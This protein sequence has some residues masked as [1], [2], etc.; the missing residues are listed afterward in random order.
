MKLKLVESLGN[1]FLKRGNLSVRRRIVFQPQ[2]H[3]LPSLPPV[4]QNVTAFRDDALQMRFPEWALMQDDGCTY[5]RKFRYRHERKTWGENG[6]PE[7]KEEGLELVPP[8]R[9][10]EGANPAH[11]LSSDFQPPDLCVKRIFGGLCPFICSS[12]L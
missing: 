2:V 7:A 5:K 9:P 4:T 12:S 6:L 8:S 11:T 1:C 3:M 10:S